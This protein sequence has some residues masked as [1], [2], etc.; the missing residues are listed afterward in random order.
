MEKVKSLEVVDFEGMPK[1]PTFPREHLPSIMKNYKEGDPD[2]E[3][4]RRGMIGNCKSWGVVVTT[5][6]ALEG[7]YLE[8][9]K[10]KMGHGRVF[11][12]GLLSLI[13]GPRGRGSGQGSLFAWLDGCPDESVLY[14]AFGSQKLMKQD[15]LEALCD[16]L[17]RSGVR[18]VLVVKEPSAQQ[19]ELGFGFVSN[20]FEDRVKGR[21]L[22]IRGWASQVDILNHRAV[23]AFLSHCG[24]NSALESILAGV[25]VLGW[26]MEADQFV[27]AKLLVDY[28]GA[29]ICVC[30]GTDTVPAAPELATKISDAINCDVLKKA[31]VK[32]LRDEAL[33]TVK[34]NKGSIECLEELV[35]Q[36]TQLQAS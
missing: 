9:L 7:V 16:G 1:C 26:P 21:G 30:E 36:L 15:Q 23:C 28:L 8:F 25:L 27:N 13:G 6:H 10:E 18:F 20:E 2:W 29:G 34:A 14:V 3:G 17:E 5:F 24:W 22:V 4:I 11:P 32:E 19:V 31:R 12:V 33:A 35:K